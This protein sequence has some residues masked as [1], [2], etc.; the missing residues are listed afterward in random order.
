MAAKIAGLVQ[1][2]QLKLKIES[3]TS[4]EDEPTP[5]TF[6]VYIDCMLMTF[7]MYECTWCLQCIEWTR[8]STW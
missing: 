8:S 7:L 1:T 3:C 5:C 6:R 2:V 4:S